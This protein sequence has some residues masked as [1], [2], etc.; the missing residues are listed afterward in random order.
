MRPPAL[1]KMPDALQ[2]CQLHQEND[3]S[4]AQSKTIP[5]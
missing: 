1:F 4:A 2:R 5:P 3:Q